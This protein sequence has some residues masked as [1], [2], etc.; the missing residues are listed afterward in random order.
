VVLATLQGLII[1]AFVAQEL[2]SGDHGQLP[3]S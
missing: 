3:G 2:A 1:G